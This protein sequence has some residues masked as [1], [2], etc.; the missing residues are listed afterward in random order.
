MTPDRPKLG[1]T[2]E[3]FARDL[4]VAFATVNRWEKGHS[5]PRGLSL[6]ALEEMKKKASRR[7]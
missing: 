7:K 6:K 3:Q 1:L 2:Q 4:G 5:S